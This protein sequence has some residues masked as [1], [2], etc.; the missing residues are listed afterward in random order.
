MNRQPVTMQKTTALYTRLSKE[1]MQKDESASIANQKLLLEEYA[2]KHGFKN[3]SH[4]SDD[5]VTGT[6]FSRPG[7]NAMLEDVTAGSVS[8]V[9]IKD[10]SR[11]GRDV[12][13]VGLL[14][15]T[16]EEHNVRF[17]AAED[18]L[19]T[20]NGFDIMSIFRDVINEWFVHDTSKKIKAVLHAKGNSGKHMTNN[21]VYG[22][23]K[24][25]D[26]KNQWLIDPEAAAVVRRIFQLTI[27]GKGPTQIARILTDDKV[28]RPSV[29][30]ALRDGGSYT[31]KSASEPY[32][33]LGKTVEGILD[34]YDYT[35]AT[36]NFRTYKDS[37]KDK[38]H[39][40]R[41][42]DEWLVF[43]D[44]QEA[45]ISKETW[46]TAQKCRKVKRRYDLG[47][48]PNPLTGLVYCGDCGGRLYNHR[49]G[50]KYD[51]HDSYACCKYTKYPPKC[52]MHYIKTST[53]ETLSLEAIR[54]V[55]AFVK[56]N[57]EEFVRQ[58]QELHDL[59]NIE[60]IKIQQKQLANHQKRYKELDSLI[61][62]I[63]E[64]KVR[65]SLS[66]KRFGILSCEYES[67][68]EGL[69]SQISELQSELAAYDN[70]SG[71]IDRFISLVRRYTD[72]PELTGTILNEYID[73]IVVFEADKSSGRR[74]QRVDIHFTFIGRLPLAGQ[75]EKEPFDPAEHRRAQYRA[76][77]HR[78]KER[79]LAEKSEK[80]AKE[81]AEKLAAQ[82]VKT[83]EQLAL[84]AE[85]KKEKYK[86]YQREYQ[87]EWRRRK[88]EQARLEQQTA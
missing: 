84:E 60:T 57:E 52:T 21:A 7:L 31:P 62:S 44:T 42:K 55:S 73:K 4:F 66:E 69:E 43:E 34:R 19:D 33:W 28:T 10:Q 5:G 61:K 37:Y 82:P 20:A 56:E 67:E 74:E 87:K 27:D 15:R 58:V 75:D 25:P 81:K 17:I 86:A 59:Q 38:K 8:T 64:D 54:A 11:I 78:N 85:A 83:P 71:N 80:R 9:I 35:G 70:E 24:S 46:E 53:L 32:T 18:G 14:K 48:E 79:L 26:D 77:Y 23:I 63:Y 47:K 36:V 88:A 3:I 76:Y 68:Q 65:G 6:S 39:K 2:K 1:D 16:L 13:E 12:V 40:T 41:H 22:Y 51:S 50:S 29:Y 30:I 45:I 72:I 49:G